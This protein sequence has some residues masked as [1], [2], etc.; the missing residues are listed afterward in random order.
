MGAISSDQ[1]NDDDLFERLSKA[2]LER[3]KDTKLRVRVKAIFAIYRLQN[4]DDIVRTFITT[5]VK[6]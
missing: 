3:M 5:R 4:P 6:K 1:I 2:L